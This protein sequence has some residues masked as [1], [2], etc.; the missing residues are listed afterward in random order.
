MYLDENALSKFPTLERKPGKQNWVDKAGGLPQLIDRVARHLHYE[1]GR[2]IGQ[3]IGTAVNWA[4]KMCSSGTAFGGK[5]KVGA[6]AQ[7][8]ACKAVAEWE[9][10][11]AKSKA[12]SVA[13]SDVDLGAAFIAFIEGRDLVESVETLI[14]DELEAAQPNPADM[15]D[16]LLPL[17]AEEVYLEEAIAG[18]EDGSTPEEVLSARVARNVARLHLAETQF[19]YAEAKHRG[20]YVFPDKAPSEKAYPMSNQGE[21]LESVEEAEGK[22]EEAAVRLAVANRYPL[23]PQR[24]LQESTASWL[25]RVNSLPTLGPVS[26][27]G[28]EDRLHPR[29]RRGRFRDVLK[30]LSSSPSRSVPVFEG[31]GLLPPYSRESQ[32]DFGPNT[33]PASTPTSNSSAA[34]GWGSDLLPPVKAQLKIGGWRTDHFA[35]TPSGRK[36]STVVSKKVFT[37]DPVLIDRM[38]NDIPAGTKVRVT[39]LTGAPKPGTMGQY[40]VI[41]AETGKFLGMVS[42]NSLKDEGP[43]EPPPMDDFNLYNP[44]SQSRYSVGNPEP[45]FSPAVRDDQSRS[46]NEGMAY[47]KKVADKSLSQVSIYEPGTESV[48]SVPLTALSDEESGTLRHALVRLKRLRETTGMAQY[49][50]PIQEL[51]KV[52]RGRGDRLT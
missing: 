24:G 47:L 5:V 17:I 49:D 46:E 30:T 52:L 6:K 27:G 20:D 8:A 35:E 14:L 19:G 12:K 39:R 1:T 36:T 50:T 13:E 37:Y 26:A 2:P 38:E 33:L 10:K 43:G 16:P 45:G 4:K 29:D 25:G 3:S 21:A 32:K 18:I 42:G 28:W 22:P 41:N 9:A 40:H 51:E 11:K 7:A 34:V 31:G 48:R 23:F 44:S 15:A